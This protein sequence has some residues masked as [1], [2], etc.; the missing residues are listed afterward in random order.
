[1][2][3]NE[4]SEKIEEYVNAFYLQ[5]V[6]NRLFYHNQFQTKAIL[7]KASIIADH[8]KVDDH[9]RFIVSAATHFLFTGYSITGKASSKEKSTEIAE[10]FLKDTGITDKDITEIKKCILATKKSKIPTSLPEK[11]VCDAETFYLGNDEF[12]GNN[13]LLKKEYEALKKRH[14]NGEDWRVLT[15]K[16]LE[17]HSYHTD[18]CRSLLEKTKAEHL[19]E[20]KSR[21][22]EK[23]LPPLTPN[24]IESFDSGKQ[25]ETEDILQNKKAGASVSKKRPSRGIETMFRVSSSNSM[26]ISEMA[27]SKA[28]IMISVNSIIISVVLGLLFKSLDDNTQLIVPTIILLTV[29]VTTIIFS[30]LATRPKIQR[31]VFTKEELE[32]K[33][34]DLIFFGNFYNMSYEDYDAG[35]DQVMNDRDFLYGSLKRDLYGQGKVLGKKYKLLHRS[36]NVFMYGIVISVVAYALALFI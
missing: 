35:M 9:E 23:V 27:D 33:S 4:I 17:T 13:K 16:T 32:N 28:H 25:N 6:D 8:Y 2:N 11:I 21:H 34:V 30:V 20:L 15:I 36:Y 12:K 1:M 7:N 3:Y 18:Y 14:L 26:K 5:H 29:N 24:T 22:H 31:G 19:S 10:K